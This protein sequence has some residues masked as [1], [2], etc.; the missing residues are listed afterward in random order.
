MKLIET[1]RSPNFDTRNNVKSIKYIILHYTAMTN[2]FE[3]IEHLCSNSNR[4][5]SHYLISKKGTIYYLVDT[6][7]SAW[8]AGNSFWKGLT[9]LN[10]HSIGIVLLWLAAF[11]TIYT[12]YDYIRKRIHHAID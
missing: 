9:D 4:V 5:S 3:A 2:H 12:G 11:L 1:F 6:N 7:N 10:S 8:H